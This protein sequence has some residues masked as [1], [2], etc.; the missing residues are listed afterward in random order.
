MLFEELELFLSDALDIQKIVKMSHISALFRPECDKAF[1]YGRS[2]AGNLL[3][4]RHGGPVECDDAGKKL[5]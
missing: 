2:D 5:L 1:R 4:L 3:E